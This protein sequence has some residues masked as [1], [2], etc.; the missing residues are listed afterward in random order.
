MLP[1]KLK[2]LDVED[3]RE[4]QRLPVQTGAEQG[5]KRLCQVVKWV[6]GRVGCIR[7]SENTEFCSFAPRL[8]LS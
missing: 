2:F 7:L 3:F 4:M 6:P 8:T 1:E 5:Q